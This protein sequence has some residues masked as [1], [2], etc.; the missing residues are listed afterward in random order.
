V[1]LTPLMPDDLPIMERWLQDKTLYDLLVNEK[2]NLALPYFIFLIKLKDDT[3]VGHISLFH[4]DLENKTADAG[5]SIPEKE[6]RGK[7]HIAGRLLAN[8]VFGEL[9]LN[10]VRCRIL[11]RNRIA[12]RLAELF[13]FVKEGIEREAVFQNGKFE[14]IYVYGLLKSDFERRNSDE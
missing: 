13:G 8:Y 11:G 9:G 3:P 2:P 1:K 4:I 6:G 14:D 12:Q 7:S 5:I 10:R